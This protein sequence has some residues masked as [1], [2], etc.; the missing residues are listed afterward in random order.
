MIKEVKDELK[1]VG[2][3]II[4][5]AKGAVQ[6]SHIRHI[7]V[8]NERGENYIDIPLSLGIV[9]SIIAPVLVIMGVLAIV[10][11]RSSVEII[12]RI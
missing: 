1:V 9:S 8:K 12:K 5:K 3:T 2:N 6:E 10:A 7:L 11:S 4:G